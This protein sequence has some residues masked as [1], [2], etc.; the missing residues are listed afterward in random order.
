LSFTYIRTDAALIAYE[1]NTDWIEP[2]L[3]E[4]KE[5]LNYVELP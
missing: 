4:M 2:T 3:T 5:A 1:G